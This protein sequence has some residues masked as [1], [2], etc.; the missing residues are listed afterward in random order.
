MFRVLV[1]P[2]RDA[3]KDDVAR[4]GTPHPYAHI[5]VTSRELIEIIVSREKTPKKSPYT[6]FVLKTA[7]NK[8]FNAKKTLIYRAERMLQS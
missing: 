3:F 8:K 7:N 5:R 1:P 6:Q 2:S 4:R